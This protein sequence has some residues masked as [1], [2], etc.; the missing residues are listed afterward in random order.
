MAGNSIGL[1]LRKWIKRLLITINLLVA[2]AFLASCASPYIPPQSSIGWVFGMLALALPYLTTLLVF[3][4]FFWLTIKPVWVLLPLVSLAIGYAQIRNTW[5]F[6]ASSPKSKQ[7]PSLRVAH[8]NVHSLT[9]ISK[10][11][12]RKQLARTEIAR[13]LK[14]TGAQVL[15]LQE[16]NHRYNE[17]GSRADNLGLFTDTYPYYNFSKDFTRDGGNYA[18]GCILF[19]KYPILASGKIPFRGKNPESII[20]IDVLLPQGDTVRIHTTHMQSFKFAE[21]DYVDIEKIKLTDEASVEASKG[22]ARKMKTAFQKRGIQADLVRAVLDT[23]P[24]IHCITG[25]YN[26]VPTSYT[27][28]KVKGYR[29]DAFLVNGFGLGRTYNDL[30]P[31]LRI[32]YIMPDTNFIVQKFQM[33]DEDL[34]DHVMLVA[35]LF[36]KP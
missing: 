27:Y 18:S 24:Y 6:T 14:E 23:C 33:K 11:K 7:K 21:R 34:S 10:N 4:V 2:L 36:I 3:S 9:G 19:S 30:A 28:R 12:E 1:W 8:W 31:T 26:D 13:T 17:P 15:C 5:G 16:F 20:F 32:D 29:Q 22:I 35:D 25:D